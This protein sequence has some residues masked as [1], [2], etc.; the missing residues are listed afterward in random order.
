MDRIRCATHHG[1]RNGN[2]LKYLSERVR[3]VKTLG[4]RGMQGA[5][6]N[7]R[8]G[9]PPKSLRALPALAH[10][11]VANSSTGLGGRDVT[12]RKLARPGLKFLDEGR[13]RQGCGPSSISARSRR[14]TD[15]H[16]L[17]PPSHS[18]CVPPL[19]RPAE[20]AVRPFKF[21]HAKHLAWNGFDRAPGTSI[22]LLHS[23]AWA[24]L[25]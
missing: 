8:R 10:G 17:W 24:V 18:V 13:I 7:N 20:R 15:R 14:A 5:I 2:C 4:G 25:H 9:G 23:S 1:P 6:A 12:R 21:L 19:G 11:L 3:P 22:A 16:P